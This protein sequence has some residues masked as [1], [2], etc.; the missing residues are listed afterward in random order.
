MKYII[1]LIIKLKELIEVM[2]G[3][4]FHSF[5]LRNILNLGHHV[6]TSSIITQVL[7]VNISTR[8]IGVSAVQV[9]IYPPAQSCR[10]EIWIYLHT[11]M[12]LR[13]KTTFCKA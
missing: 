7:K 6:T 13:I 2:K 9:E 12:S 8:T 10:Q 1:I 4:T 5:S 3:M 11:E